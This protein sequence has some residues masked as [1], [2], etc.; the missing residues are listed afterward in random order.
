MLG[1]LLLTTKHNYYFDVMI[2]F[3]KQPQTTKETKSQTKQKSSKQNPKQKTPI[4]VH[5]SSAGTRCSTGEHQELATIPEC[6]LAFE[7]ANHFG[8]VI[9][10][11]FPFFKVNEVIWLLLLDTG[12]GRSCSDRDGF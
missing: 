12:K 7:K 6:L 9:M 5:K 10:C 2:L 1:T 11:L 3:K 8:T 4:F